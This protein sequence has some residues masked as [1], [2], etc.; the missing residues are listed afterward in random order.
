MIRYANNLKVDILIFFTFDTQQVAQL[1]QFYLLA[2]NFLKDERYMATSDLCEIL[3][4]HSNSSASTGTN[5]IGSTSSNRHGGDHNMRGNSEFMMTVE[6]EQKICAA[7]LKLLDDSSNDVQSVAVKALGEVLKTVH[8]H[9]AAEIC[10]RL[11]TLVLD[12][13]RGELRDIYTI[14]LKKLCETVPLR[15]GEVVSENLVGRLVEGVCHMNLKE[16]EDQDILTCCLDVLTDLI[17]KFG[18][19]MAVQRQQQRILNTTMNLCLS[20]ELTP[21]VKKKVGHLVGCIAVVIPDNLLIELVE[22]LL[23]NIGNA[24]TSS[25]GVDTQPLIQTVCIISGKVGHRLGD[26][27]DKIIPIFLQFCDPN[28]IIDSDGFDQDMATANTELKESCFLGFESFVKTCPKEVEPHLPK[29]I[30]S[31]IA[32]MKYDPNYCDDEDEDGDTTMQDASEYD[33]DGEEE[34]DDEYADEYGD[35]DYDDYSDDDEDDDSW[36]VRRSAVRVLHAVIHVAKNDPSKLWTE[37]YKYSGSKTKSTMWA[38]VARFKEREEECKVNI[39]QCITNLLQYTFSGSKNELDS[40]SSSSLSDPALLSTI[41]EKFVPA[42]VKECGKQLNVKKGGEKA[43]SSSLS[44]LSVVCRV[45]GG[46]GQKSGISSIF[47]D[48]Q[49]ILLDE[50][51]SKSLKLVS[52][53]TVRVI[54][55][56]GNHTPQLL[57]SVLSDEMS[58]R[59]LCNAAKEDW[60]KVIAEALHVL[61]EIPKLTENDSAFGKSVSSELYE[62]ISPKLS[63]KDL[64]QEIKE[65]ALGATANLLFYLHSYIPTEKKENLMKCI[66]ERLQSETTRLASLKAISKIAESSPK[67]DMSCVMSDVVTEMANLLRQQ[68][69]AL[70]QSSLETLNTLTVSHGKNSVLETDNNV[71]DS[72]LKE[73]GTTIKDN[74]IHLCHLGLVAAKSILKEVP[75]G[76]GPLIQTRILPP[77]LELST[78]SLLQN[79]ALESL[80]SFFDD[81]VTS[82]T[83]EFKDILS[84]LESRLVPN[85]SKQS[86]LNLAKCLA[87]VSASATA[88]DRQSLA[89]NLIKTLENDSKNNNNNLASAQLALFTAGELGQRVNLSEISGDVSDKL[90]SISLD[91]FQSSPSEEVKHAASF[92]LGR[93]AVGGIDKFLPAILDSLVMADKK[94]QY[95]SLSSL[96]EMIVCH[97]REAI[98]MTQ[99]VPKI[100]PHLCNHTADKEEGVRMMVAECL[101]SLTCLE[102]EII[103]PKLEEQVASSSTIEP[104]SKEEA[105][106]FS[107]KC[108]TIASSMKFAIAAKPSYPDALDNNFHKFLVLL[109]QNPNL[110][111]DDNT[112]IRKAA[113]LMVYSAVHHAPKLVSKL[114]PQIQ[115]HLFEV[116]FVFFLNLL[117]LYKI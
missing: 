55:S 6:S 31:A 53:S 105:N 14:G 95:L 94:T 42:I 15:M 32:Y 22:T 62:S 83:M 85:M 107:N 44:L 29:I 103:L 113:L 23:K 66:L 64:D 87:V 116:R 51:G 110:S 77:A 50:S 20:N 43:K 65:F 73:V 1:V 102:P 61:A 34:A 33:D 63:A 10:K 30:Q 99:I 88:E 82:K 56:C 38:L 49:R 47:S 11:C 5:N 12:K 2:I 109:E 9:Q 71:L 37:E 96:K 79:V 70:K 115:P 48:V 76:S 72:V 39:I 7:V 80:L 98:S 84:S 36:K 111:E 57:R 91:L 81:I 100:Y 4:N 8:E 117:L 104:S 26:Q 35:E 17:T 13:G 78:S 90:I 60:Y 52:L 112:N 92:A 67:I 114:M 59:A 54:L 27:I 75:S 3:K 93:S 101:G 24:S 74:D 41:Q 97:Q 86:L 45:P 16:K 19:T 69:R 46:L 18:P 21:V 58:L 25:G 108:W 40:S 89:S 28:D 68:N 106:S